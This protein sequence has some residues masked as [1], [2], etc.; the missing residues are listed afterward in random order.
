MHVTINTNQL[1]MHSFNHC[2]Y[3]PEDE[4]RRVEGEYTFVGL[5][6]ASIYIRP[7]PP[8]LRWLEKSLTWLNLWLSVA[9]YSAHCSTYSETVTVA[10]S[11]DF[12]SSCEIDD[13]GED[14]TLNAKALF[15]LV[16]IPTMAFSV[17]NSRNR[18]KVQK[19]SR[20]AIPYIQ[21]NEAYI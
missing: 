12:N 20:N 15:L 8:C 13:R 18:F 19:T 3:V 4:S 14:L 5:K 16:F 10:P 2:L 9:L 21:Y 1:R 11:F 17:L 7:I 6:S